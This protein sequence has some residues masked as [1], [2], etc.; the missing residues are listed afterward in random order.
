MRCAW[1]RGTGVPVARLAMLACA[2]RYHRARQAAIAA[3]SRFTRNRKGSRRSSYLDSDC[4]FPR[5][6]G[7]TGMN[8]AVLT[9]SLTGRIQFFTALRGCEPY[10]PAT[11]DLCASIPPCDLLRPPELRRTECDLDRGVNERTSPRAHPRPAHLTPCCD[12]DI[13][14]GERVRSPAR[15]WRCRPARGASEL[16]RPHSPSEV[17]VPRDRDR[18]NHRHDPYPAWSQCSVRARR[19]VFS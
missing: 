13:S 2:A 15:R 5:E 9:A 16:L 1:G 4:L 18:C 19:R 8:S 14:S 7:A 12:C 11:T 6:Q 3:A 17:S 10:S